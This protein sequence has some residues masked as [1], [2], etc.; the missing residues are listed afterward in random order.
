MTVFVFEHLF[1]TLFFANRS[2]NHV[3]IFRVDIDECGNS[4]LNN[5][6]E[7]TSCFDTEGSFY[8]V[9][10]AGYTGQGDVYCTG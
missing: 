6:T 8:C 10:D 5:C 2:W 1:Y 3:F 7:N 9:C 4:N